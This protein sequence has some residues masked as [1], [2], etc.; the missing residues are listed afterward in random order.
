M[1]ELVA[2]AAASNGSNVADGAATETAAAADATE[3]PDAAGH[4]EMASWL[5][6]VGLVAVAANM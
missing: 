5:S 1:C 3:T 2:E 6:I 4:L